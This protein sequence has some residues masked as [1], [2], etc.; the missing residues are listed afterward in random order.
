MEIEKFLKDNY[1]LSLKY[2]VNDDKLEY[3][4]FIINKQ[5]KNNEIDLFNQDMRAAFVYIEKNFYNIDYVA[6]NF[7][8]G[9][10]FYEGESDYKG[11]I[12]ETLS[13]DGLWIT[14][15][16]QYNYIDK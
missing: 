10:P 11:S 3:I 9:N 13:T 4:E 14:V 1:N 7:V 6:L 16:R 2:N 15:N 8:N 12:N 5:Y